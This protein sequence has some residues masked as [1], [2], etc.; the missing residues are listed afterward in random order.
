MLPIVEAFWLSTK[1]IAPT[2]QITKLANVMFA[3]NPFVVQLATGKLIYET[4]E[5]VINAYLNN[6][7][8]ID[9][10]KLSALDYPFQVVCILEELVHV[11]MNVKDEDLVTKVVGWLYDGVHIQ[12]GKYCVS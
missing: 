10:N 6:I 12:N 3:A 4:E 9:C 7:I 1:L 8:F 2:I 11:L 5:G